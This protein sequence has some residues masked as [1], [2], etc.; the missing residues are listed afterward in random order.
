MVSPS[1]LIRAS[2]IVP[3]GDFNHRMGRFCAS[4]NLSVVPGVLNSLSAPATAREVTGRVGLDMPVSSAATLTFKRQPEMKLESA[5][6]TLA[7]GQV[8]TVLYLTIQ[9]E[10]APQAL[11]LASSGDREGTA[12]VVHGVQ[13]W[14]EN[15]GEENSI[16]RLTLQGRTAA[17]L[18]VGEEIFL[19]ELVANLKANDGVLGAARV[20]VRSIEPLN[21]SPVPFNTFMAAS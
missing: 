13:R 1:P 21:N 8:I 10:K 3:T 19:E 2:V 12:G 18:H 6:L 9:C 16:S 7:N 4:L 17:E 5:D 15:T 20:F 14:G 11:A